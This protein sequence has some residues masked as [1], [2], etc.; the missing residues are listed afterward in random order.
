MKRF[1]ENFLNYVGQI[2][3]YSLAD[4]ILML[5]ALSA[6]MREFLGVILLHL[7]FL[8]Y[9]EFRHKHA[10]RKEFHLILWPIFIVLG[11]LLYYKAAVIGFLL[12]SFLYSEKNKGYFGSFSPLFRGLQL[13]FLVSGLIG[14]AEPLSFA[15]AGLTFCR[16][17]AGDLRD[18]VKDKKDNYK[19]LPI[20]FGIKRNF[21]DA[22]L[23]A[24]LVTSF[25]WWFLSGINILWLIGVFAVEILTYDL[26]PR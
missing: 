2:R 8:L 24:L 21:R 3:L 22:H 13:Y 20:I 5:I 11:V 15:A 14:F 12:A 7:G 23:I 25:A 9:L 6:G 16:N 1:S 17:F 4:L 10:Y 18:V 19:T 26:T